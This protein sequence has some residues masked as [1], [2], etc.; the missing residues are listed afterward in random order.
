MKDKQLTI[1]EVIEKIGKAECLSCGKNIDKDYRWRIP[2][3]KKCRIE[4]MEDL[5][6]ST[7]RT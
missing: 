6:E 3:C 7:T 1:K 2:L 4:V 5:E